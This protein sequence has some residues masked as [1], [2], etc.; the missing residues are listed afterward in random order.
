MSGVKKIINCL[1]GNQSNPI[2]KNRA[3]SY[4]DE[5]KEKENLV[6]K[7]RPQLV[8][9]CF[10]WIFEGEEKCDFCKKK[11]E[12]DYDGDGFGAYTLCYDCGLKEEKKTKLKIQRGDI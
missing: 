10:H 3:R 11:A 9:C 6:S 2:H 5:C 1:C 7:N 4:C 8:G 12:I